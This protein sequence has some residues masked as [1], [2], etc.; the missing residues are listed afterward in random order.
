MNAL[1]F[2]LSKTSKKARKAK[3]KQ[4]LEELK[5]EAQ[6]VRDFDRMAGQLLENF[7]PQV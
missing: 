4:E 5:S 6:T 1:M 7:F 3:A 2:A